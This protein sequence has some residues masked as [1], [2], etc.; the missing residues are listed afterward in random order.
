MTSDLSHRKKVARRYAD[1]FETLRPDSIADVDV[2]ISDDVHFV[3][4]F[5]DVQGRETFHRIIE[6]MFDDVQEPR[7]HILDLSWSEQSNDLCL[8]RWDFSCNAPVIGDWTVRGVTEI[9]FNE[10]DV[11]CAHYDYWDA[12]RHFYA[13]L[14]IIGW[15]LR[16]V[17]QKASL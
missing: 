15:L 8:M 1:Y 17:A 4:P 6:K 16:K 10:D 5:N 7:F 2:L 9:R 11:I 12:S 14:P 3:D 13:R